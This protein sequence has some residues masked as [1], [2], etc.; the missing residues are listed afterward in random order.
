MHEVMRGHLHGLIEGALQ[1][2]FLHHLLDN[3][4]VQLGSFSGRLGSLGG[5]LGSPILGGL[6]SCP[7]SCLIGDVGSTGGLL[8]RSLPLAPGVCRLGLGGVEL[9]CCMLQLAPQLP[10]GI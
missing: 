6:P 8:L 2:H 9:S 10:A 1:L 5:Q 7:L 3:S 4:H